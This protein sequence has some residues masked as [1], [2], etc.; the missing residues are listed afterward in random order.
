MKVVG[1]VVPGF[2]ESCRTCQQIQGRGPFPLPFGLS[3]I[4]PRYP[5]VKAGTFP[6]FV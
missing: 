2:I 6:M 5:Q 1:R 3:A 4:N